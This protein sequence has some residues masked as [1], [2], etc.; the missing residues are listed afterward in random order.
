MILVLTVHDE[1]EFLVPA[2]EAGAAG[3][4]NKSVGDTDLLGA[5]DALLHGHSYLP[6]RA[7]ALLARRK[8]DQS[9]GRS[10]RKAL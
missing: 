3:F 9:S 8:G 7:S 4:L 5:L 10:I 2:M 1:D 6:G